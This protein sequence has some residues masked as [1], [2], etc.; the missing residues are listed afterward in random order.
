MQ[1]LGDVGANTVLCS[2][3]RSSSIRTEFARI[4]QKAQNPF[5]PKGKREKLKY[6]ISQLL[7]QHPQ[8]VS[9]LYPGADKI[10]L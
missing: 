10:N 6:R 4:V 1:D 9:D 5:V 7:Q 2:K 8:I 3:V